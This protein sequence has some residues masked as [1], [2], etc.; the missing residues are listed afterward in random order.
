MASPPLSSR[1]VRARRRSRFLDRTP[2]ITMQDKCDSCFRST[3]GRSLTEVERNVKTVESRGLMYTE[4]DRPGNLKLI[5]YATSHAIGD[6]CPLK[7]VMRASLGQSSQARRH[8][9][10]VFALSWKRE[11]STSLVKKKLDKWRGKRPATVEFT[12]GGEQ[13]S[14]TSEVR[15]TRVPVVL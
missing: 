11:L 3:E 13:V 8:V 2:C 14:T 4:T 15:Y 6:V 1:A 12:T 9:D 10:A 5:W 7:F